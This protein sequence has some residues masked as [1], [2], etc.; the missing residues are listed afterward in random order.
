MLK[1]E[2]F[3]GF[4]GKLRR[5]LDQLWMNPGLEDLED[6][7]QI[8]AAMSKNIVIARDQAENL[9]KRSEDLRFRL[10]GLGEDLPEAINEL[11]QLLEPFYVLKSKETGTSLIISGDF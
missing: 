6:K 4:G 8:K 10:I 3:W 2:T 11:K 5:K 9:L 1:W 7:I